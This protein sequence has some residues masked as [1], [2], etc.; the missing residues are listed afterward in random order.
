MTFKYHHYGKNKME[1]SEDI[2]YTLPSKGLFL[3]NGYALF[4]GRST[5][6]LTH[7]HHL[8][9][10]TIGPQAPFKLIINN[11]IIESRAMLIDRDVPHKFEVN[12]S[13]HI[14][15]LIDPELDVA[16]KLRSMLNKMDYLE[17]PPEIFSDIN[18][19]ILN[20]QQTGLTPDVVSRAIDNF[21]NTLMD[22][23]IISKPSDYRII[24]LL[25]YINEMEDKNLPVKTLADYVSL[26]ESR[27]I[28]LFSEE[29]GIPIRKYLLWKKLYTA[30][31]TIIEGNDF[32]YAAH[33]AGFADSA[34]LSRTFKNMFGITLQKLFK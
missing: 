19:T 25:H 29:V 11:R 28:H 34:H 1:P 24:K 2:K 13:L 22:R 18:R 6:T 17:L 26:S 5:D 16:S 23:H 30:V 3:Y 10:I 15:L 27:L 14:I 9:Q 33:Q 32:T 7:V 4:W 20:S 31:G 12:D 8:I 21:L